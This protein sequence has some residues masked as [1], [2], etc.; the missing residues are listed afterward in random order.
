MI[1]AILGAWLFSLS[2]KSD[3]PAP[4]ALASPPTVR[5]SAASTAESVDR[6]RELVTRIGKLKTSSERT[7]ELEK[8]APPLAGADYPAALRLCLDVFGKDR[9]LFNEILN[10]WRRADPKA[11]FLFL[12]EPGI[13]T[14]GR[15]GRLLMESGLSAWAEK[16]FDAAFEWAVKN[17]AVAGEWSLAANILGKLAE[18]DPQRA[19]KIWRASSIEFQNGSVNRVFEGWAKTDPAMAFA[20]L[21]VRCLESKNLVHALDSWAELDPRAALNW[22]VDT[23]TSLGQD[24]V[25][26]VMYIVGS[27]RKPVELGNL[28]LS[29]EGQAIIARYPNAMPSLLHTWSGEDA[30]EAL[31]W[32]GKLDPKEQRRLLTEVKGYELISPEGVSQE[33]W[34]LPFLQTIADPGERRKA[35][36]EVVTVWGADDPAAALEW[37]KNEA[38]VSYADE[39]YTAAVGGIAKSDPVTAVSLINSI[40]DAASRETALTQVAYNWDPTRLQEALDWIS[41]GSGLAGPTRL[42][43]L[44]YNV[45]RLARRDLDAAKIWLAA[46]KHKLGAN[47]LAAISQQLRESLPESDAAVLINVIGTR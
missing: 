32:L 35:I 22:I 12:Q 3:S 5:T 25:Q 1:L 41:T 45:E 21:G 18:R 13:A 26:E 11:A 27:A 15:D 39:V 46:A 30:V 6:L 16:D 17:N 37:V 36:S 7:R 40:T 2:D 4:P 38:N 8:V 20:E 47:D 28:L 42:S 43:V 24:S 10:L 23:K 34:K 19:L 31:A 9:R 33:A 44:Q 29:P 14:G